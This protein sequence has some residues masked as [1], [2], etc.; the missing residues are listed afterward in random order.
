MAVRVSAFYLQQHL[1]DLEDFGQAFKQKAQAYSHL[2]P[3]LSLI[4]FKLY[5]ICLM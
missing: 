3:L 2:P 1:R 5:S 4:R